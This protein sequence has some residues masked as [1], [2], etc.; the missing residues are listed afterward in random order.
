MLVAGVVFVVGVAVKRGMIVMPGER[1]EPLPTP[2]V[3]GKIKG[4]WSSMSSMAY[5]ELDDAEEMKKMGI[6][7]ITF[8]PILTHDV[9][10]KVTDMPTNEI[11]VK[12]TINKAHS[13]GLR[14]WL[15]TTPMN[16]GAVPPRVKNP[17]LFTKEMTR[18][19]L[20]YA[21]I[22]EEFGV[23]YFAP[24]VE[25]G[26]HIS[27]EE[28]DVWLQELLPKLREVYSGKI[29]WKKQAND[30]D[31][32]KSWERDHVLRLGFY[33]KNDSVKIGVKSTPNRNLNLF[34]GRGWVSLAEWMGEH[35]KFSIMKNHSLAMGWHE[36]EI[37]VVGKRVVIAIDG[38]VYLE[39]EDDS[40]PKGGY[41]FYSPIRIN[42]LMV[43]DLA[44]KVLQEEKF[45][46][47]NSWSGK[48]E[49][50]LVDGEIILSSTEGVKL[51]HDID[52][53][54]F[55][56][57][58][59][60]T[61]HRG[62]VFTIDEYIEG[63]ARYVQKSRDQAKADGVRCVILAEFGGSTRKNIGWPD[64]DERAKIPLSEEELAETTRRVLDLVEN[65]V[66]GYIYNG[67]DIDGQGL[68]KMP[69][70]KTVVE[71]WYTTH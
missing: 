23:E 50:K 21:Q 42:K 11:Y 60:D 24:V 7:T 25:P 14:V 61:F 48:G 30:L 45:E 1:L 10:G 2:E 67:W 68:N 54:G 70:V 49:A 62:R 34:V 59:M 36:L 15:E 47:L 51:I 17:G 55:D 28:A 26:H 6:N 37:R 18:V 20:K 29:I 39:H 46:N 9:E 40:G 5:K 22:A 57:I 44:G 65:E 32:P 58:A 12:R 16:A 3:T 63:L 41:S 66:D 56:C 53:S 8:S 35:E 64:V 27:V 33:L 4:Y 43:T 71:E 13:A 31:Q 38:V 69:V 19:A 52:F